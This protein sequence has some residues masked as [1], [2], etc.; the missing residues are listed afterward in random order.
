M[1]KWGLAM[2]E[3]SVVSWSKEV[4][5]EIK[6]CENFVEIE[7]EKVVNEF[8]SPETGVLIKKCAEEDV[9]IPVGSLLALFGPKETSTVE[10]EKFVSDFE[11]NFKQR[12]TENN[13]S[14]DLTKQIEIDGL[15]INYVQL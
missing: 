1:P 4:G 14:T 10:I 9:K 6:K 3:G 13:E 2:K 8:E 11:S 15:N 7:T 12:I 5:D